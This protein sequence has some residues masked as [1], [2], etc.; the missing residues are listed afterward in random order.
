MSVKSAL[1]AV[2]LV[3]A[4]SSLVGGEAH[5][6]AGLLTGGATKLDPITLASGKPLNHELTYLAILAGFVICD[7]SFWPGRKG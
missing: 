2:A 1:F 7:R 4:L 3:F 6:Q 5:A